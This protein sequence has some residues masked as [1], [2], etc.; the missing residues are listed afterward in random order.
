[1]RVPQ[2]QLLNR[3]AWH[4]NMCLLYQYSNSTAFA[5][6][7]KGNNAL[8]NWFVSGFQILVLM[9]ITIDKNWSIWTM[10]CSNNGKNE[11][12]CKT[13]TLRRYPLCLNFL[14]IQIS[15]C[16]YT[17]TNTKTSLTCSIHSPSG[18][19]ASFSISSVM[20]C[21]GCA[22]TAGTV[23]LAAGTA[24]VVPDDGDEDPDWWMT[25]AVLLLLLFSAEAVEFVGLAV[26]RV[27]DWSPA[28]LLLLDVQ[29]LPRLVL[30]LLLLMMELLLLL[31]VELLLLVLVILELAAAALGDAIAGAAVGPNSP[32]GRTR[33]C[34]TSTT[35]KII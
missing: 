33:Y 8:Y 35:W 31:V 24:A 7:G 34:C 20:L 18:R 27:A 11:K 25:R 3:G 1:M 29:A 5:L 13:K 23:A 21:S 26:S 17:N 32:T 9:K 10:Q 2:L 6:I 12:Y 15:K 22:G 16:Q 19:P 4:L 30:V 14:M 28:R